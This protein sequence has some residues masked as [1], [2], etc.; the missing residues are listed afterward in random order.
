MSPSENTNNFY[1]IPCN[2]SDQ[3]LII[4]S[5]AGARNFN[6]FKLLQ[7]YPINRLFIRDQSR[8]WY[9]S[10]VA[11]HW[12]N[13][14]GLLRRIKTVADKFDK[15]NVTCMG[16][17]MG[18]YA[19]MVAAAKLRAGHAL[20]FS[21]QTIL[22][23]R[24]PNNPSSQIDV[25]Y[26]N[27]FTILE[28]SPHTEVTIYLGTEDLVDIYN[29]S[30]TLRYRGFNIKFLYGAPHNLMNFLFQR[31]LL[32]EVISSFLEQRQP[33][34]LFPEFNLLH[35]REIYRDIC[36][37]VQGFYFNE[38]SFVT[39][40]SYLDNLQLANPHWAAIYHC[41]GKLFAKFGEHL[42]AIHQL[43]LAIEKNNNDDAIYFD[44]GLSAIQA[45]EYVKAEQAL[46]NA[47][48]LS[49]TPSALYLSK[50]GASLMLQKRNEE[51]IATQFKALEVN[52]K[53]AP[54]Y[55]QIGLTLNISGRY[56]D[57]IP[58][59]ERAI[60]LGDKNPNLKKHLATAI[61]NI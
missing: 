34:I 45:K 6:C 8:S 3:L 42:Q 1:F 26:K 49:I 39:L 60:E 16:G 36:E 43:E 29:V 54:A 30:P 5:G 59:F 51:A 27:P 35:H 58:M 61:K 7:D 22:D 15:K 9:Q 57:A 53:Y 47:S 17:S 41:R 37:F 52:P 19:A 38:E 14:D 23:S 13:F 56:S 20:L 21:P 12:D 25:I 40:N 10:P 33:R 4:F 50:L 18:G 55:Y 11:D 48:E 2:S 44:L 46:L 24:L 32:F 28:K 31:N